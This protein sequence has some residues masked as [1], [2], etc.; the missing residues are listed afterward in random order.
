MQGTDVGGL[1]FDTAGVKG[2][3]SFIQQV[4]EC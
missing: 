4:F 1:S 3:Y 2:M